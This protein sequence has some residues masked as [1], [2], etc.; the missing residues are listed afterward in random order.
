MEETDTN[1]MSKHNETKLVPKD[2]KR[3]GTKQPK[4]NPKVIETTKTNNKSDDIHVSDDIFQ[5][6]QV[7]L[8]T[9]KTSGIK[10]EN[11]TKRGQKKMLRMKNKVKLEEKEN[12]P[13]V[14]PEQTNIESDP[15]IL[16]A[17]MSL[18][19][20]KIKT[21]KT[22]QI[23]R[24]VKKCSKKLKTKPSVTTRKLDSL[25]K[26][27]KTEEDLDEML[28]NMH[29]MVVKLE[30]TT[31]QTS[32]TEST[33][34]DTNEEET[35]REQIEK[36]MEDEDTSEEDEELD[37]IR[38]ITSIKKDTDVEFLQETNPILETI[39]SLEDILGFPLDDDE[40]VSS[41]IMRL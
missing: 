13:E 16:S 26:D 33:D 1:R 37:E 32:F 39:D 36:L 7:S 29:N 8:Y 19:P 41:K 4:P 27:T 25:P 34:K 5:S 20:R 3:K 2:M 31:K 40:D 38:E 28:S 15:D 18:R 30:H 35:V 17:S 10:K 21:K 24:L 6:M 22:K 11:C 9:K 14:Q 23:K 12:V